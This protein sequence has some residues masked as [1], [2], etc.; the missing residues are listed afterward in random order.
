MGFQQSW[1][2]G[3]SLAAPPLAPVWVCGGGLGL[4]LLSVPPC[5]HGQQF[6]AP[7]VTVSFPPVLCAP[8]RYGKQRVH[9][10]LYFCPTH[11]RFLRLS[12]PLVSDTLDP[13]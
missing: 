4:V 10:A 13:N 1:L 12:R 5:F 2:S 8:V 7:T 9:R 11:M 3:R 6:S